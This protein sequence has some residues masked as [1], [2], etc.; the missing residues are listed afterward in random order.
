M[1]ERK[2]GF[3]LFVW[4]DLE[5]RWIAFVRSEVRQRMAVVANA[6]EWFLAIRCWIVEARSVEPDDIL[7]AGSVLRPPLGALF[8]DPAPEGVIDSVGEF[9]ELCEAIWYEVEFAQWKAST[10]FAKRAGGGVV[11]VLRWSFMSFALKA[12]DRE[13]EHDFDRLV[14]VSGGVSPVRH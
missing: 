2:R 10:P 8:V 7:A 12:R 3:G 11:E 13:A 6:L 14:S 4:S 5:G 9:Y 1:V